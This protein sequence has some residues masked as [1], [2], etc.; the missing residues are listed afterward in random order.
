MATLNRNPEQKNREAS[1]SGDSLAALRSGLSPDGKSQPPEWYF[2]TVAHAPSGRCKGPVR[3]PVRS[4]DLSRIGLRR[5]V[6]QPAT[7]ARCPN[8][9]R[10]RTHPSAAAVITKV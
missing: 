2:E 1:T 9:D 3:T 5:S 8:C 10:G 6:A 7:R 4:D